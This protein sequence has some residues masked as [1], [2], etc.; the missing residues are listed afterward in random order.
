MCKGFSVKQTKKRT[1]KETQKKRKTGLH[2]DVK[3]DEQT[4]KQPRDKGD[5]DKMKTVKNLNDKNQTHT[6]MWWDVK[7]STFLRVLW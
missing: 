7:L 2:R 5:H 4:L 1:W 6:C 3:Q